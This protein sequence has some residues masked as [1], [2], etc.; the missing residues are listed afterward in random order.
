[1]TKLWW[2]D[3]SDKV[4]TEKI[5][6]A[7]RAKHS[8]P[9][10]ACITDLRHGTGYGGV[11]EQGID[12]IAIWLW[13]TGYR[14]GTPIETISVIGYEVKASRGD[15]A[16]ELDSPDK[17]KA[18][19]EIST[20]CFFAVPA[21]L[22]KPDEIPEGWGLIEVHKSGTTRRKKHAKQRELDG[23]PWRLVQSLARKHCRI[24]DTKAD[25]VM[26]VMWRVAGTELTQEE[27]VSL[28]EEIYE[29]RI[30]RVR[31]DVYSERERDI[32]QR[33]KRKSYSY[34]RRISAL[35]KVRELCG[36]GATSDYG[37]ERWF[38]ENVGQDMPK[39]TKDDLQRSFRFL[40]D[41]IKRHGLQED[42]DAT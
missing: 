27:M 38:K 42:E 31:G 23:W 30:A 40:S 9:K 13:G 3:E 8:A 34:E 11:R 39:E 16:K 32:I 24:S 6:G 1:M 18:L 2:K 21:G 26:E 29:E 37:F 25:R 20:E 28:V 35:E 7:L 14:G 10:W 17:R 33:W 4:I 5:Y 22:V 12:V 15:F 41:A 19:E 36:Y